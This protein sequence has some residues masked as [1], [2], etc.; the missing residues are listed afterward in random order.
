MQVIHGLFDFGASEEAV[1]GKN[2]R[3]GKKRDSQGLDFRQKL[4]FEARAVAV[5]FDG[6]TAD[7]LG[8]LEGVFWVTEGGGV[9]VL[10]V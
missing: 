9:R 1:D 8:D 3:S 5:V 7:F 2:E 6:Q 10:T 4:R